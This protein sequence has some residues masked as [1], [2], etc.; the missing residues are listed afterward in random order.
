[1]VPFSLGIVL[2]TITRL[3]ILFWIY[4]LERTQQEFGIA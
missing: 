2:I 1:M 4:L 3:S